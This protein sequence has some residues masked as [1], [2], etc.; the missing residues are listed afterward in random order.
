MPF[1]VRQTDY[2]K[3]P[4]LS[5][6]DAELLGKTIV[7]GELNMHISESYYGER[8]VEKDEAQTLLKNSAIINMVGDETVSLS[9]DLG[10][11]SENGVKKIS[12]VPF[13]IVF[14]M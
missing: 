14:K 13:L 7:E 5:I 6:C 9:I 1:A 4:M 12:G 11:G 2:Q 3:N 10:I 8:F